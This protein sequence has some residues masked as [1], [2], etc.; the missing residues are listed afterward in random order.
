[1]SSI[2]PQPDPQAADEIVAYLD[3]E[4]PPQDCRRVENRLASDENYRQQLHELDRAWEAL[5]VLPTTTAG[6]DFARTT[7]ELACIA[8]KDDVSERAAILRA[9]KRSRMW[10]W[11]AAS[12]AA[13]AT[14]LLLGFAL[15]PSSNKR[16]LSDLP[17]IHQI[18]VLPYLKNVEILRELSNSVPTEQMIKDDAAF[19]RETK[20]LENANDASIDVRRDWVRSL[21][22]E[23]KAELA[24]R[25][26]AFSELEAS[27]AQQHRMRQMMEDI[28]NAPDATKLDQTLAAYGQWLSRHSA[29]QQHQLQEEL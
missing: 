12:G 26:R 25:A 27:P 8:A 19:A 24:D 9:A 13:M 20:E 5:D 2:A 18:N 1:M 11:V 10:R 16:L 3:G 7:I 15:L 4:L 21:A 22:P 28:R 29:G 6:D 23:Q 14:G 17:A